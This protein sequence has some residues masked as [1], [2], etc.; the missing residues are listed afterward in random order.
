MLNKAIIAVA[1][2]L[3][4]LSASVSIAQEEVEYKMINHLRYYKTMDKAVNSDELM[5]I[6]YGSKSGNV[7]GHEQD[8]K[9]Q[10]NGLP[11]AF[12]PTE[13]P[14]EVWV[15]D[16]INRGLKLFKAGKLVRMVFINKEMDFIH[17]FAISKDGKIAF[18]N[19]HTGKVYITNNKGDLINSFSGFES[20]ISI[21]FATDKTLLIVSPLAGGVV[22]VSVDGAPLGIYEAD[23]TLSNF[24]NSKGLWGL[25]C[26]G[27]QVA[28]LYVRNE[29]ANS[30][31]VIAEFPFKNYKDVEYKGGNIYGFDKE[32]NVYFGLIACDPNGIIYRDRIY[33]CNQE[34]KVLKEMDVIDRPVM[35]PGLPRHRIVG[36]DGRILTFHTNG[37][38]YYLYTYTLK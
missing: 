4:S 25:E 37:D 2:V 19:Q 33:K 20:A 30:V 8:V 29:A 38:T 35:S 34:G 7:G 28:K 15:L 17:D 9:Q 23:Q 24:S 16:S 11:M 14:D 13:T 1:A 21:E 5:R 36:P 32:G 22:K 26:Y 3:I 18:L 10:A 31:K 6:T 27:G 12:R